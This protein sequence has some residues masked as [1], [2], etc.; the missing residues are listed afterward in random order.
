MRAAEQRVLLYILPSLD[1]IVHWYPDTRTSPDRLNFTHHIM[2]TTIKVRQSTGNERE[3]STAKCI[4][5]GACRGILDHLINDNGDISVFS[6]PLRHQQP[7]AF[8]SLMYCVLRGRAANRV[9]VFHLKPQQ[10]LRSPCSLTAQEGI[11]ARPDVFVR[12]EAYRTH[13]VVGLRRVQESRVVSLCSWAHCI[14]NKCW[15]LRI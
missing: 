13:H 4:K 14:A 7:G 5:T 6:T 3:R 2:S 9:K 12:F 10:R 15:I 11:W 8:C 1:S